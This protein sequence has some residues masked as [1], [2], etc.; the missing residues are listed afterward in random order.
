MH[1][2]EPKFIHIRDVVPRPRVMHAWERQRHTNAHWFVELV[3]EA[4]SSRG[5]YFSQL[6]TYWVGRR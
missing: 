2:V 3:A 4:V 6:M 5:C 1:D